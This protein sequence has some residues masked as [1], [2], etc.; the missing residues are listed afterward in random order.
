MNPRITL[1]S[2]LRPRTS[3]T[4]PASAP[5]ATVVVLV[6]YA[7]ALGATFVVT[8][9]VAAHGP[10]PTVGGALW[11]PSQALTYQW[12]SGQVPPDW[13]ATP[14]NAA[15]SDASLS[16]ASRAA[17]FSKAG[18]S[19]SLIAY[20]EPT[21]CSTAGIACFDRSGAP[22]SFRMWFRAQGHAFDW[23]TL[24]WCQGLATIANG[25]FDV[26]TIALDEFGHVEGLDHHANYSDGSDYLDAVVQTVS[27]ARPGVGWQ[28]RAFG[29]CDTGRLQLLYDRPNPGSLFSSCL[30]VPTTT[31]LSAS[32]SSI[33]VG[34]TVQLTATLRTTSSSA[35]GALA[36]DPISGRSVV[37]QRRPV[38]GSTWTTIGPMATGSTDGAYVLSISPT[39]TYEWRAAFT[40]G[41]GDGAVASSSAG[42]TITVSG[43]SGTGCP[44]RPV[45]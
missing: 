7:M 21:G 14:I 25:C 19:A 43:C 30:S 15:A 22:N 3:R 33:W 17:T 39:A 35:N 42:V 41:A 4:H 6:L 29:R 23:G 24:R 40:P 13:M 32:S 34:S 28:V 8:E 44:S 27:H 36:N 1:P 5:A 12:R 26:E 18:T 11:A 9:P 38:G 16:R 45:P 31:G 10:D 37:A 20:G 2:R